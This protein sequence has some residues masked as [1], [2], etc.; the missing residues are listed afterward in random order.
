M[1]YEVYPG[2]IMT[3]AG[4]FTPPPFLPCDG[5][6][7]SVSEYSVLFEAIGTVFGGDGVTTF[8]LPDL[9]GRVPVGF[10]QGPDGANVAFA[11]RGGNES[12]TLAVEN[13]PAHT[14]LI[15]GDP[16]ASGDVNPADRVL[17]ASEGAKMYSGKQPS[18]DLGERS[19]APTGSGLPFD[20]RKPFVA[21]T[22]CI[23]IRGPGRVTPLVGELLLLAGR[24]EPNGW[25][26]CDGRLLD[27]RQHAELFLLIGTH[28]GGDGRSTFALPDL[29]AHVPFC[30]GSSITGFYYSPGERGGR[31]RVALSVAN[32]PA[33][34]H[35]L[36]ADATE[37]DERLPT[38]HALG[39]PAEGIYSSKAPSAPFDTRSIG[40][41]GSG[42]PFET[43]QP[44]LAL[45]Y[46][47][48]LKGVFPRAG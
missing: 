32:M 11:S 30:W 36:L 20:N 23:A 13:L 16:T 18:S 19:I 17:G 3:F 4:A 24:H 37:S 1:G 25:A 12:L 44:F 45:N 15:L 29:R 2:E 34:A 6:L 40:P 22:Y 8:A 10:G 31:E 48:A 5:Q 33:H 38:G 21:I 9:R 14:H 26:I 39:A 47:I 35:A 7:L 28:Y 41:T 27:I 42:V 43:H 46:C